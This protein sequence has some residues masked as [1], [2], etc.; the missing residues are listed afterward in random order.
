MAARSFSKTA[1][2]GPIPTAPAKGAF[3]K[4]EGICLQSRQPRFD[5]EPRLHPG[6]V[7]GAR[8]AL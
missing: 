6:E 7:Y 1:S 5:S 8:A 3:A 2:M 4:W